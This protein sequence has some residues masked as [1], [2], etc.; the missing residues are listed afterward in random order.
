MA[1]RALIVG[2]AG[3]E[4]TVADSAYLADVE[5]WGVIIFARNVVDRDQLTNLTGQI[6]ECLAR[7]DAPIFVDQEGGRVQRLSPPEWISYPPAAD[8]A[9]CYDDNHEKGLEAAYLCGRLISHDL[10]EVGITSPCLPVLDVPVDHADPVIGTRAYGLNARTVTALAWAAA[11]GVAEGGCLPVVKHIPGHGRALC[12]SHH[13]LPCVDTDHKTLVASDFEPFRL[14]NSLP[15]AMTG[16]VV[17]SEYDREQPA[18]LSRTI[19]RKVIR[20]LIGFDGLLMTDDISMNALGGAIDTRAS[21][22]LAAG[23]DVI[24]HCNGDAYEMAE[25]A[26]CV[27][28]L[29]GRALERAELALKTR[30]EPDVFDVGAARARLSDLLS[31]WN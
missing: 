4:L 9:D 3:S 27:N 20:E 1:P 21:S 18:T 28:E 11:Y 14:L 5:P 29:S 15:I 23:C 16:H 26:E 10:N 12:D 2:F 7:P 13:A 19:I 25:L 17:F 6:R 31:D 8:I 22:A 30:R 24:L